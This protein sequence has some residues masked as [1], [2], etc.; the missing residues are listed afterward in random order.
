MTTQIT[1]NPDDLLQCFVCYDHLDVPVLCPFCSKLAC[2]GCLR[3]WLFREGTCPHCRMALEVEQL[4]RA[5][6][7]EE[8]QQVERLEPQT[9]SNYL[10]CFLQKFVKSF[11]LSFVLPCIAYP[12]HSNL[13]PTRRNRLKKPARHILLT[14]SPTF[15][16]DAAR[17]CVVIVGSWDFIEFDHASSFE[18]LQSAYLARVNHLKFNHIVNAHKVLDT[19]YDA[20]AQ[21]KTSKV[22][23]SKAKAKAH[24]DIQKAFQRISDD[25]NRQE[26]IKNNA[27]DAQ[28]RPLRDAAINLRRSIV[29]TESSLKQDSP[30]VLL[31][32]YD[33]MVENLE[34][35]QRL[36]PEDFDA[37]L[38]EHKFDMTQLVP[39]PQERWVYVRNFSVLKE[40][41]Q[42]FCSSE[43]SMYG[44]RWRLRVCCSGDKQ[45]GNEYLSV[46]IELIEGGEEKAEYHYEIELVHPTGY[47]RV[48]VIH[49]GLSVVR[50]GH[51]SVVHEYTN[52][53]GGQTTS[54]RH[55][56]F[57]TLDVLKNE[58][59][60]DTQND[61]LSLV[62]SVRPANYLQMVK[63]QNRYIRRL[64]D[65]VR[66]LRWTAKQQNSIQTSRNDCLLP[67]VETSSS[68]EPLGM[69]VD[70]VTDTATGCVRKGTPEDEVV[71]KL[72]RLFDDHEVENGKQQGDDRVATCVDEASES[73]EANGDELQKADTFSS[74]RKGKEKAVDFYEMTESIEGHKGVIESKESNYLFNRL[75]NRTI[76]TFTS[77][78]TNSPMKPAQDGAPIKRSSL[79]LD[80]SS[81]TSVVLPLQKRPRVQPATP[82]VDDT[83]SS[84]LLRDVVQVPWYLTGDE[85]LINAMD[86]EEFKDLLQKQSRVFAKK[87]VD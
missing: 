14:P 3:R 75:L 58:G 22:Q 78:N 56:E 23:L 79:E 42:E 18:S 13:P 19:F 44:L 60:I 54:W 77:Q 83:A 36:N 40:S 10:E 82:T 69:D 52:E 59:F 6:F 87:C 17:R 50:K 31:K 43:M 61:S 1:L 8:L 64:E 51:T 48:T 41:R 4:V 9:D 39:A 80:K 47:P 20:L 28:L 71:L 67:L 70:T 37:D 33:D 62:Y 7:V 55:D 76:G 29:S 26:T 84:A 11:L 5:R 85:Y 34:N 12:R 46:F 49:N 16:A 53:F 35:A 63:L 74:D 73:R 21:L 25:I 72:S 24:E 38:G 66:Q 68:M 57:C 86:G 81:A 15:V 27:L 45:I 65:E 30:A 2:D 32:K